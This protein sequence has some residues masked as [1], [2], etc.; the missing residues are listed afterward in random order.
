MRIDHLVE[1]DLEFGGGRRHIDIRF[2]IMDFG[3][4]DVERDRLRKI[5]LGVVGTPENLEALLGWLDSCRNEVPAKPNAAQPNLFPPFPGFNEEA[6]FESTLLIEKGSLREIPTKDFETLANHGS[7][8]FLIAE[9]VRLFIAELEILQ[10]RQGVDVV[11]LAVPP[12]LAHAKD[13]PEEKEDDGTPPLDFRRLVKARAMEVLKVPVQLVLPSTYDPSFARARKRRP[14]TRQPLQDKATRAWNL[15]TA[16]YYKAGGTPWRLLRDPHD[17]SACY[18][19]VSFY[20]NLGGDQV[21]TSMAQVFNERGDGIV[22]RGAEVQVTK[23]DRVPHL[24]GADA[25]KLLTDALERYRSEHGHAPARIV[26]HKTSSFNEAEIEGFRASAQGHRIDRIDLV[27]IE[28]S[29]T[30][31][32]RRGEYPPLRGTLLV[33]D[34]LHWLYTR[35]SV[36]F[37]QTYPGMYVPRPVT[38]RVAASDTAPR[39]LATEILSLTKMNWNTTQFD[40]GMPITIKA[41]RDVGHVLKYI[42]ANGYVAPRYSF[43]M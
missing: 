2:G 5:S 21:Q 4:L 11:L 27:S 36:P 29:G 30:R 25:E 9:A 22:V 34:H 41:A 32:F 3:P 12:T 15:H 6:G 38:F 18:V 24:K 40:N 8:S 43:Y 14:S 23:R 33:S 35:G 7:H 37:Y 10:E 26:L 42:S 20:R 39:A 17:L 1:P 16:L 28:R 31:L 19:G 13:Q